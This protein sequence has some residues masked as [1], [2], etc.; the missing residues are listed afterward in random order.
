[1]RCLLDEIV[2]VKKMFIYLDYGDHFKE[3]FMYLEL[4][5]NICT[6]T[7]P[8]NCSLEICAV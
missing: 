3:I 5:L 7:N 6:H 8:S 2:G 4:Y 1:M